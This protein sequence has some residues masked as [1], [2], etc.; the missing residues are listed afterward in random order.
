MHVDA[1]MEASAEGMRALAEA[2]NESAFKP[3]LYI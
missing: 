1:A 3:W 2:A